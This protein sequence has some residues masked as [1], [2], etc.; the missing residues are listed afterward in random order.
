MSNKVNVQTPRPPLRIGTVR[1]GVVYVLFAAWL[2]F[3]FTTIVQHCC[4]TFT[5]G[6]A[7][8]THVAAITDGSVSDHG[9]HEE[10]SDHCPQLTSIDAMA[11]GQPLLPGSAYAVFVVAS[12]TVSPS[13]TTSFVPSVNLHPPLPPWRLY[14]ST[15][16]LRI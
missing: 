11:P 5:A 3:A 8:L 15:Q 6:P 4:K 9:S 2:A 7:Q 10:N 1:S 16:R 14:L 13:G 12:Y